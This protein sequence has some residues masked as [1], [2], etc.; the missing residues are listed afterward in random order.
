MCVNGEG[1]RRLPFFVIPE[2]VSE[3][4]TAWNCSMRQNE[5]NDH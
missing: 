5:I 1:G 3:G 2:N 4:Y